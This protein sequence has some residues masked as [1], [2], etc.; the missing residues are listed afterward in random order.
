MS[1]AFG[2]GTPAA[3]EVRGVEVHYGRGRQ[4]KQVLQGVDFEIRRGE[5]VGL[6]GETGS[7]KST[8]ARTVLGLT[9]ATAGEIRVD[10]RDVAAASGRARRAFRRSGVVQYVFQDPQRS[11]DQDL[12]IAESIA[13]PL[14]IQG[15]RSRAAIAA[16]VQAQLEQVQLEPALAKRFPGEISGGQRQRAAIARALITKPSLL[17][18]DE[19]VSALDSA[20]RVRI[21]ELLQRLRSSDVAML[22]ISHDLGSVAGVTERTLVLY[23]G[24]LVESGPT[25]RLINEPQHA[26]TRLLI[27]S[28]PTLAGR[29]IDRDERD[30]L[31]GGLLAS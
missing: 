31:R 8:I 19:P 12:T 7:G 17:I 16:A 28:A 1:E 10:G 5:A 15:G 6:I 3:L 21:L 22:F 27:G 11:L 23:R 14:L 30:R 9:R 2:P 18:L 26:Y 24:E 20:N 29:D 25:S 4:R 13:E